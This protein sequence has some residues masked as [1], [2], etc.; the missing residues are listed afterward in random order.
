MVHHS[1]YNK[2]AFLC[3]CNWKEAGEDPR[4]SL[5]HMGERYFPVLEPEVHDGI[6]RRRCS[7]RQSL[8]FVIPPRPDSNRF[9]E[10]FHEARCLDGI[11]CAGFF[12]SLMG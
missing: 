3:T 12:I 4:K 8:G 11:G 6:G 9:Q 1:C 7:W 10:E 2:C 5:N